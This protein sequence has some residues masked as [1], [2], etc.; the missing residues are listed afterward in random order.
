MQAVQGRREEGGKGYY[1]RF[2]YGFL[3]FGL[4]IMLIAFL[5]AKGLNISE[6]VV[7]LSTSIVVAGTLA[8]GDD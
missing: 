2:L 3:A 4:W 5:K 7:W 8:G 6:D 1:M